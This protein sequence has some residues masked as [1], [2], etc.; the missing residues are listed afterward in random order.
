[1]HDN[2]VAASVI[3]HGP[4]PCGIGLY[5]LG[6]DRD[7]EPGEERALDPEQPAAPQEAA[8]HRG[9]GQRGENDGDHRQV[10]VGSVAEN[11]RQLHQPGDEAGQQ[12]G[13]HAELNFPG[14]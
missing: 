1:M 6:G 5:G 10:E 4:A 14:D 8:H 7:S 13:S 11:P 2:L 9:G 12:P 3:A